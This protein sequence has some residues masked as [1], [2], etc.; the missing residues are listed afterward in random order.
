MALNFYMPITSSNINRFLKF[1]YC[2]DQQKI[3]NNNNTKNPTTHHRCRYT[4]LSEIWPLRAWNCWKLRPNRCRWRYGYYWQPIG[5]RQRPIRWHPRR[6]ATTYRL[7]TIH[8]WRTDYIRTKDDNHANSSTV[9]QVRSAKNAHYHT[10]WWSARKPHHRPDSDHAKCQMSDIALT[11]AMTMTDCMINV[12]WAWRVAS[13]Q[14]E[15]K[16]RR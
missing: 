14:P 6:P 5:S 8:L 12:D 11:P 1:F 10:R 2:R 16:S 9:A 7:A 4:T 13:K 15:F 3:C